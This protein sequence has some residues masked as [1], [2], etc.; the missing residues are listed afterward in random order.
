MFGCFVFFFTF[1]AKKRSYETSVKSWLQT[2]KL[3]KGG[4]GVGVGGGGGGQSTRHLIIFVRC[5]QLGGHTGRTWTDN[6][7]SWSGGTQ[8]QHFENH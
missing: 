5:T 3:N 2:G 6:Y 4:S 7:R 8:C 1:L